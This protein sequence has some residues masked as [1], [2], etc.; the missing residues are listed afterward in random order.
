MRTSAYWR[1]K[2]YKVMTL[3]EFKKNKLARKVS[4]LFTKLLESK[5]KENK[6]ESKFTIKFKDYLKEQMKDP[7]FKKEMEELVKEK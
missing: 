5:A 7:E 1:N 3:N 6:K 2:I 4:D